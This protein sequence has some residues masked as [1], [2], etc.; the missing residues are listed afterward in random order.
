MMSRPKDV[1]NDFF[2]CYQDLVE[3]VGLS[4]IDQGF[5]GEPALTKYYTT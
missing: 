3:Y 5:H 1:S 4:N 2:V